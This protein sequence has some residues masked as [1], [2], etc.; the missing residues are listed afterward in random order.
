MRIRKVIW[1]LQFIEKLLTKH[2]VAT[3]EAEEVLFGF[4]HV[5]RVE[6]GRVKGEDVYEAFGQ[7]GAGRYLVVFFINKAGSALPVSARDMTDSER[8]YYGKGH[9]TTR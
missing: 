9:K 7:T 4:P 5:L 8:R 2:D 3:Q 1:K 6:K